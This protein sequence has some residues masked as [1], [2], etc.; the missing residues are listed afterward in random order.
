MAKNI[1]SKALIVVSS[2]ILVSLLG[3]NNAYAAEGC[4]PPLAF[5]DGVR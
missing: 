3:T 2:S 1:I 5:V 4:K